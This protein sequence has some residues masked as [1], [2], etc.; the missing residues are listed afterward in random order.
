MCVFS[1]LNSLDQNSMSL[2]QKQSSRVASYDKDHRVLDPLSITSASTSSA[3]SWTDDDDETISSSFL[4]RFSLA[5]LSIVFLA[6]GSL[7]SLISGG[8]TS[9]QQ[10]SSILG[11]AAISSV[12]DTLSPIL[13]FTGGLDLRREE[14]WKS[15]DSLYQTLLSV[16][17]QISE[18]F[19]PPRTENVS[20]VPSGA[21]NVSSP[22][23]S[24]FSHK[25]RPKVT[26]LRTPVIS[27]QQP[28]VSLDNIAELTLSDVAETFRYAV[29]SSNED[30]SESKFFSSVEPRLR[31]VI[32]GMKHAVSRSR[33]E[34]AL[35]FVRTSQGRTNNSNGDSLDAL[36]F[37]AAMRLLAEW[38]L[39]RQVPDGY[40][41]Y[42]VGMQLGHKD[43]VQNIIKLESA[44]HEYLDVHSG[45]VD[46]L[47]TPTLRQV[48]EYEIEAGIQNLD[49]LPRLAEKSAGMG[50]LWVRRQ[51]EYQT[52]IFANARGKSE[53]AVRAAY[54]E[55]Y[56][57]Y[58][59]WAVQKIFQYS[60]KSAPEPKV[61]FRHM[62]PHRL[63]ELLAQSGSNNGFV[64]TKTGSQKINPEN[65]FE[66]LIHHIGGEWDKF[67]SH[68]AKV[69][70]KKQDHPQKTNV[71]A[72]LMDIHGGS[73]DD[74]Y[75][76]EQ[77]VED[78]HQ[79]IE[80][81]LEVV[82]PILDALAQIFSD[83]NMN[84]PTR[85]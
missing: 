2:C 84:D 15:G 33:G 9:H 23:T 45:T 25:N 3:S 16:S 27:T 11:S 83:L 5:K 63:N 28:F 31:V 53:E 43:V 75:V 4:P 72:G 52:R 54:L 78:G 81:Y 17:R 22:R 40:K 85:V 1:P 58:H 64:A 14:I 65:P 59:G 62:N 69:V 41:G 36:K 18:A 37:A 44:I 12:T 38:R 32:E 24:A 79:Q 51:L 8:N 13:P 6:L 46:D 42:A 57:K 70:L 30:F 19:V 34:D 48:L 39:L 55:V 80:V 47:Q 26:S 71:S 76:T 29:I 67:A 66:Q 73:I 21:D 49:K 50:L 61:I 60:F 74:N 10:P 68:F 56:D 82:L 20:D 77:M 35:D 7:S